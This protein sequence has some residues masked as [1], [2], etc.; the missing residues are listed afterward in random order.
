MRTKVRFFFYIF[1]WLN[2]K[3]PGKNDEETFK[4]QNRRNIIFYVLLCFQCLHQ[5]WIELTYVLHLNLLGHKHK[6][7]A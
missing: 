4:L 7:N 6:Q 5:I 1:F 2:E 3:F